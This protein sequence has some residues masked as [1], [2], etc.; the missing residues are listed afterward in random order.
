MTPA[1]IVREYFPTAD[2][3]FVEHALWGR[4]GFPAFWNGDPETMM[5]R[6]LRHFKRALETTRRPLCD[7]CN[8]EALHRQTLCRK[9]KKAQKKACARV[10]AGG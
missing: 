3:D 6:Q 10:G 2:D 7:F 4:T 8:R 5:R 1:E 9:D